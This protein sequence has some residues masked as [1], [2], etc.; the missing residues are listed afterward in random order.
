MEIPS[1]KQITFQQRKNKCRKIMNQNKNPYYFIFLCL[2]KDWIIRVLMDQKFFVNF[3]DQ[4]TTHKSIF[5]WLK[6]FLSFCPGGIWKLAS[7]QEKI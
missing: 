4:T 6:N 2:D 5:L 7:R 1:R 3:P